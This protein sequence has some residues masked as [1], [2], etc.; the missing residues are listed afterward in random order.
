MFLY[1]ESKGK[2]AHVPM[3]ITL[4]TFYV[5]Y[6]V[7]DELLRPERNNFPIKMDTFP[8]RTS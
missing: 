4:A 3:R 8:L 1:A 6:R 7:N 5:L 2:L